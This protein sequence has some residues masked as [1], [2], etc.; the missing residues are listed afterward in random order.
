MNGGKLS[1]R[2]GK[3][4]TLTS[5]LFIRMRSKKDV[6]LISSGMSTANDEHADNLVAE[7]AILSPKIC[8]QLIS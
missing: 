7:P 6:I 8:C 2:P 5:E 1:G 3:C 4:V